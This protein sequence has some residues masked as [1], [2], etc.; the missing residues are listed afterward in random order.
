[1]FPSKTSAERRADFVIHLISLIGFSA[2]GGFLLSQ[3]ASVGQD[4]L[5]L[6]IGIYIAAVLFSI[7]ISFA[8]HLLP[9]QDLRQV[10]RRWDHAAIYPVIA[11]TFTPLL[12]MA[13]TWSAY[14]ILIAVWVLASLG[15]VFKLIA[16]DMDPRWSVMSYLGLGAVGLLAL[17][18]FS[19]Q[20]PWKTTIAIGTGAL[21]YTVG[22]WFYRQKDMP[23]RYPIWHAWGTLGGGSLCAA[24][25]IA[26][27][28]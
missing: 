4:G 14:A 12:I 20:L 28:N 26:V 2:A 16:T 25:W 17:P 23:F 19:Q 11:G 18:D 6:A 9:R 3:T 5:F 27:A 22:T 8:Y 15:I 10:L 7:S 13:D 1:M 24:I 21:L